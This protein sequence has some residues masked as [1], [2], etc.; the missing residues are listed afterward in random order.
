MAGFFA[1]ARICVGTAIGF[2]KNALRF[3]SGEAAFAGK[4]IG[5]GRNLTIGDRLNAFASAFF[6]QGES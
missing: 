5:L 4:V 1:D 2:V 3:F 6:P